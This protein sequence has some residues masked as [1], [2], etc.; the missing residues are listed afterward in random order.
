VYKDSV[1]STEVTAR[2]SVEQAATLGWERY[3]GRRGITIGMDTFGAS[4]PLAALQKNSALRWRVSWKMRN[5]WLS[6]RTGAAGNVA[7]YHPP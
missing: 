6:V 3:A 7:R 1:L 4:A 2:I 5:P